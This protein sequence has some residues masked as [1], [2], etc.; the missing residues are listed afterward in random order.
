LVVNTDR[1]GLVRISIDPAGIHIFQN[2]NDPPLANTFKGRIVQLVDE[3][4]RI[5]ALVD[6][7]LPLSVLISPPLFMDLSMRI[8]GEVFLCCPPESIEVF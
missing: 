5:R 7:G 6:I 1:R 2:Q 8:G 3:R 4:S